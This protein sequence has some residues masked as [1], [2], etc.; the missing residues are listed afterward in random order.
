[1]AEKRPKHLTTY[2]IAEQ[3][4]IMPLTPTQMIRVA[5]TCA[6]VG[7]PLL[8]LG[9]PGV[10]KTELMEQV[11]AQLEKSLI[12]ERLNG[13]DPTDMGLPYIHEDRA[14]IK[15]HGWSSP[16]WY[17]T[18]RDEVPKDYPGGWT[19]FFDEVPQALPAMQNRIGEILNE[20]HLNGV[21]AHKLLWVAL[22][23]NFAQDKAATYPIPRQILN[24]CAVFILAP[25]QEDFF[26]YCIDHNVRPEVSG[27]V[28]MF[29]EALD[30]Y[31]ADAMTNCT[32]R[33]LVSLSAILDQN[34]SREDE[35]PLFAGCIGKGHGSQFA[36][37]R[38]TWR[39]LPKLEDIIARPKK[40]PV[41]D[42]DKTDVMC[43]LAAMLGRAID[44]K[45]ADPIVTYLQRI[46]AEYCVFAL[47]DA[48]RRDPE[49]K[50][51]KAFHDWAVNH[52]DVL[53]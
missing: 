19:L 51:T 17:Q 1:M 40:E 18:D 43:A 4:G 45:N 20:K 5:L 24:R 21:R 28:K 52:G 25:D 3:L 9:R 53:T 33:S 50:K 34:P 30:S 7:K 36:G 26:R 16:D 11:S 32:P 47:R 29:P 12:V 6:A 41:P 42:E 48:A 39:G 49:V 46:P 44:R 31:D 35:L 37:F 27:Y 22:A 14:G 38:D 2:D 15:R 10:G 13:R 23:G 8:M